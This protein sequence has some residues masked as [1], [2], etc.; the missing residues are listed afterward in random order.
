MS[1]AP[2]GGSSGDDSDVIM[3]AEGSDSFSVLKGSYALSV[4]AVVCAVSAVI[5]RQLPGQGW[6]IP[7]ITLVTVFVAT[8]LPKSV[9]KL[10]PSGEALAA[11]VMQCFFVTVGAAGS[12]TAWALTPCFFIQLSFMTCLWS[13]VANKYGNWVAM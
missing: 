6:H 4:A 7:V 5:A 9:G 2:D 10:A 8:V 1:K 3:K 11:L 13:G 12:I